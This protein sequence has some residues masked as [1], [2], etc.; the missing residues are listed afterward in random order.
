MVRSLGKWLKRTE[1]HG[2]TRIA[3]SVPAHLLDH[4]DEGEARI[5]NISATGLQV[6]CQ[7]PPRPGQRVGI[8]VARQALVGSAVWVRKT[9]F[10]I[11]LLEALDSGRMVV[12]VAQA[13]GAG[14]GGP[15]R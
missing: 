4:R 3:V 9:C 12:I 2:S 10:G 5:L 6:A 14:A 13:G 11:K 8:T 7:A 1:R 15:S